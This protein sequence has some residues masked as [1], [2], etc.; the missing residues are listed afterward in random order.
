MVISQR[1]LISFMR[2]L[3][4][5]IGCVAS[6]A[7]A[8]EIE[9]A[10]NRLERLAYS[11]P[12]S[13]AIELLEQLRPAINGARPEQRQR[14]I[15]IES[16]LAALSGQTD[17]ALQRVE[18]LLASDQPLSQSIRLRALTLSANLLVLQ[19][20]FDLGFRRF[21]RALALA[22]QEPEAR[23]RARTWA[24]A[25]LFNYRIG[26]YATAL[27][28]A[29]RVLQAVDRETEPR[30]HCIG[31]QYRARARRA[32]G[33]TELAENDFR[34]ATGLCR[35]APD[36]NYAGLAR[37]GLA[38]ML[39]ER[40]QREAAEALAREA[41]AE[42]E[43]GGF[44]AGLLQA[45]NVL[46]ELALEANNLAAAREWLPDP[47]SEL[48]SDAI[49]LET[50]ARAYSLGARLAE[51]GGDLERAYHALKTAQA[52]RDRHLRRVRTMRLNL[53][54]SER[55]DSAQA[56]ER[57]MLQSEVELARL[58]RQTVG[59]QTTLMVLLGLGALLALTLLL[60]LIF[61]TA[62]D[63]RHYRELSRRDGLTGLLN[64]TRF[65]ELAEQALQ[66]AQALEQPLTLIVFDIDHF[67]HV[68]DQF[69]HLVGDT[70]LARIGARVREAFA[71]DAIA[72][73]LGGEEFGVL[74]IETGLD[75]AREQVERF[76]AI[77]N[78]KR[79]EDSE[80]DITL[81]F[82][83]VEQIGETSFER[84]YT[85]ADRAMYKAKQ[86]GRNRI[87]TSGARTIVGASV[88]SQS[89]Q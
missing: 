43:R 1:G 35:D 36:P 41:V 81:S 69:G 20:R 11:A 42:L 15:L 29:N 17:Q 4:I 40:G 2:N 32:L 70:V 21:R 23:E 63:R 18:A 48:F 16:R 34:D 46:T 13:S 67:K 74:L 26:E 68:N 72:G 79:S 5:F 66:R 37:L 44:A 53:L 87:V 86:S 78:R 52:L 30:L 65:F 57:Q 73:R 55:D 38:R 61:R 14:F 12:R 24:V 71:G 64:H 19:N 80:P 89:S 49:A 9:P 22:E 82:G 27:E 28:Y 10:L 75:A 84:L 39:A 45:R 25:S 50:Q 58:E 88:V 77:V 59:N 31:L 56:R 8:Q 62:R 6:I 51:A 83:I 7:A 85:E 60:A 3:L 33:R 47:E 54:L 76:R